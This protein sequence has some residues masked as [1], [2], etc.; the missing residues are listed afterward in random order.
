VI[1]FRAEPP[2]LSVRAL[3]RRGQIGNRSAHLRGWLV[4]P[5]TLVYHLPPARVLIEAGRAVGFEHAKMENPGGGD[6]GFRGLTIGQ[7]ECDRSSDTWQTAL[8]PNRRHF[9]ARYPQLISLRRGD[10]R[11]LSPICCSEPWRWAVVE[12]RCWIA[13]CSRVAKRRG[14]PR[15]APRSPFPRYL[16]PAR[17]AF[18]RSGRAARP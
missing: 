13:G 10:Q 14:V 6:R 16:P 7:G 5:Q 15:A 17:F 8:R 11:N 18:S 9:R 1:A 12:R 2:L 4:R 3:S